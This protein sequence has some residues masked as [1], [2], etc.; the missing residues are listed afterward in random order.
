MCNCIEEMASEKS[1]EKQRPFKKCI[2]SSTLW[3]PSQHCRR[4]CKSNHT[5]QRGS[6]TI[7]TIEN[8]EEEISQGKYMN[9]EKPATDSSATQKIPNKNRRGRKGA[10]TSNMHE[11]GVIKPIVLYTNNKGGF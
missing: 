7:S 4:C 5:H 9:K 6:R 1:V 11:S 10:I 2:E 8:S 3:P